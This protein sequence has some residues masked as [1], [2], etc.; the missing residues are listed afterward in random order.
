MTRNELVSAAHFLTL[1]AGR[2]DLIDA[3]S[4]LDTLAQDGTEFVTDP[5]GVLTTVTVIRARIADAQVKLPPVVAPAPVVPETR[6][7][8]VAEALEIV[9]EAIDEQH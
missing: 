8:T 2:Q 4:L 1:R 9:A 5:N 3:S 7:E 6:A